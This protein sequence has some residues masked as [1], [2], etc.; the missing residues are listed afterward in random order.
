MNKVG[1]NDRRKLDEYLTSVRELERRITRVELAPPTNPGVAQPD[2]V[3]ADYA[4][5]L[6]LMFDLLAVAFQ[7]DSTRVAT[8]VLANEASN[9]SYPFIDVHDGHHEISH[10]GGN[11]E[12]QAKIAKINRFHM[13]QFARF[14]GKL[15][16]T[17]EGA[18]TVLDHSMIVYGGCIGDGDRHNHDDLPIALVG[19]GSGRIKPGRHIRYD[20]DT[21]LNNLWLSMLDR[22]DAPTDKLGDSTGRLKS[23]EG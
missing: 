2:G 3:P 22:L 7:T 4:E 11:K 6:R 21:P 18:G 10:H 12:K 14:I 23:L 19:G 5:H 20:K 17:R 9:R 15:H 8:F 1:R 16:D 13:E